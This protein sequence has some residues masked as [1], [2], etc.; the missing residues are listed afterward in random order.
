MSADGSP[1]PGTIS[2]KVAEYL[3]GFR[4]AEQ[5]EDVRRFA[6]HMVLDT[7]GCMIAGAHTPSGRAATALAREWPLPQARLA[8]GGAP[9][10]VE[11]AA[12]ANTIAAN[13]S[14]FESVGPEGHMGAVA[15]PAALALAE[16][17]GATG[18]ALLGAVIAGLEVSGRIGAAL[19][20][21]SSVA[22]GGIPL[23]RGTPHAI[24]AATVP[25]ALL[26]GADRETARNALGIA[27]YSA[28]L[29]TL[30][31]V[32]ASP[33]PPMT[34]YDHLG[35]MSLEGI[36]AVRLALRGFTGDKDAFEGDLGMWRFSGA[37]G[38][39]WSLLESFG[40]PW[41]IGPT[42]FKRYPC[43]LY[44]NT[45]LI[46]ARRIVDEHGLEPNQIERI[47]IRPSRPSPGAYGDGRGSSM[48]QW[49]SVR[50]NVAHAICGTRPYSAWQNGEPPPPAVARLIERTTIE[51]YVA[52]AG[53]I[54]GNYWDGYSPASVTIVT[55]TAAYDERM[56]DLPRLSE[57]DLVAK[58]VE[59]VASVAGE[60]RARE[61][62]AMSLQLEALPR[63]GALLDGLEPA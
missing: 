33:D 43:I 60:R 30:R 16:W 40:G 11:R 47:V 62:A 27:A 18:A 13:A 2:S 63:A 29:P 6:K 28:H 19:R 5:P 57:D 36:D 59:N 55:A 14:D 44:E 22:A 7:L 10:C 42:F 45:L 51:P 25:A 26:L 31:K 1:P 17:R 61:L 52:A 4:L 20:R 23:V 54:A 15:V 21:P 38:C 35:G 9:V 56:V 48:A 8:A 58:F 3:A 32:M 50:H 39:D 24:F 12:F 34:K 53:E 41:M 46:A 37:L 49:M